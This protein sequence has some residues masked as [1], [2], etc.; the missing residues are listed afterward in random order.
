MKT[1]A[2]IVLAG[3]TLAL[4]GCDLLETRIT[5]PFDG[6]KVTDAQLNAQFAKAEKDAKDKADAEAAAAAQAIRDA[7]NKA[8][9]AGIAL[10]KKQA[11][12]AAEIAEETATI[13]AET[14]IALAAASAKAEAAK[15]A[16]NA[17]L[18]ALANQAS[19]AAAQIEA[20]R[21]KWAGLAGAIGNIPVLKQATSGFG[22]DLPTIIATTLGG[23]TL[24]A[25]RAAA[26]AKV[27]AE[28]KAS[29]AYDDGH[30]DGRAV[31]KAIADKADAA[32]DASQAHTLTLLAPSIKV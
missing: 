17:T 16:L 13:Q 25:A 9:L 22:I 26:N 4:S 7:Q 8:V 32:W 3:S 5:S 24:L 29:L 15:V 21:S 1:I 23:T 14:G 28:K 30:K 11:V 10:N 12:T 6:T 31:E 18:A 20:Q 27:E 19:D 2:I